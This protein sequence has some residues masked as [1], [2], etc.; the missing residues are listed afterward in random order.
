MFP[1]IKE[2]GT[3]KRVLGEKGSKADGNESFIT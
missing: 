3:S 1:G 2:Q